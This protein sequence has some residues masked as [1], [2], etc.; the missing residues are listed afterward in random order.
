ML[1]RFGI[2]NFKSFVSAELSLRPMTVLIGANASGK[3]NL[4]EGLRLLAW[5]ASGQQ[6]PQVLSAIRDE[7]LNLRGTLPQ[8]THEGSSAPIEFWCSVW[9]QS[10]VG[11]RQLQLRLNLALDEP[12]GPRI[13]FEQLDAMNIESSPPLYV[14]RAVAPTSHGLRIDYNNFKRGKNKPQIDGTALQAVF[15]QLSTGTRF[16]AKDDVSQ[17]EIP[18]AT[19]IVAET[20]RNIFVLD[21]IPKQMRGYSHTLDRKL[22]SDGA[23]VSAV[24]RHLQDQGSLGAVLEFV[25]ALPEQDITG[26]DFVQ[27][28][29]GEVMVQLEENFG[30]TKRWRDAATLSD[31]TLRVLAIAAALLSMSEGATV[32]IEEVDNGIHPPRAGQILTLMRVE[33]ERRNLRLLVTTH[34]PVLLDAIPDTELRH[35]VACYRDPEQGDSRLVAL[36]SLGRFPELTAQGHLGPLVSAG[37]LERMLHEGDEGE[38]ARK[39]RNLAWLRS[40]EAGA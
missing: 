27:T 31:G 15:T 17:Q 38:E 6:L 3:S 9:G 4:L 16:A 18:A 34:N 29:R 10:R 14:G 40:L 22:R 8:L 24:L 28:P 26:I 25:R 37:I 33:A 7:E 19:E 21:P 23:N 11:I 13:A 5:I 36:G 1:T 32:V 30:G 35:V 20:L 2:G 39:Q 12:L